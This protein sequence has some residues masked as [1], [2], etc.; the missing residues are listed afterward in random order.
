MKKISKFFALMLS[1]SILLLSL[2]ACGN[3]PKKEAE[4]AVSK[5][6]DE[7]KALDDSVYEKYFGENGFA[8]LGLTEDDNQEDFKKFIKTIVDNLDYKIVSSEEVDQNNVTVKVDVTAIKME[9]VMMAFQDKVF[10]FVSSE[11]GANLSPDEASKK[12]FEFL[13]E[14][15]SQPDLETITTT[16]DLNVTKKDNTWEV[17]MNEE[18]INA[19]YGGMLDLGM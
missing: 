9:P 1:L 13:L 10:E 17:P 14:A 6:F 16:V 8:S 2:T 12:T 11:E 7:L 15:V 4:E 19:I 3:D 5:S 18:L